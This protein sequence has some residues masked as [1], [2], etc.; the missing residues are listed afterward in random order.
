MTDIKSHLSS[1]L[2]DEPPLVDDLDAVMETG[3]RSLRRHNS[4]LAV[5]GTAG[6]AALA[7]AVAVPIV[8]TQ[9]SGTS[10]PKVT[11]AT[12][13]TPKA[14]CKSY[15]FA[16]PN[17]KIASPQLR[18][19]KAL[20]HRLPGN[21]HLVRLHGHDGG[22]SIMAVTN[23]AH[24]LQ[25]GNDARAEGDHG[26]IGPSYIYTEDPQ[27]IA[28]RLGRQ[29]NADVSGQG[30]SIVS[31][32]PFAQETSTM[33]S[34]HPAYYDGNVDVKVGQ[35]LGSIGV[36]VNHP[37]TEQQPFDGTC[38][39]TGFAQCQ[40]STLPNGD[41]LQTEQVRVG[42]DGSYIVEAQ[43]SRTDGTVVQVQE[44]NYGFGPEATR[45]NGEQ[46]LPLSDLVTMAENPAYSF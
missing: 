1:A 23:C 32:R 31:T 12:S 4:W 18:K 26:P 44:S 3:R 38:D 34:G 39:G 27:H 22:K 29:L 25:G 15:L 45:A 24:N 42:H 35:T 46:P 43:V 11:A 20:A 8:A 5:I 36:Q 28:D 13:P 41:V 10:A 19:A 2:G 30:L 7:T 17:G 9:Q 21:G 6:A 16:G 33:D 14:H 40:R 37:T